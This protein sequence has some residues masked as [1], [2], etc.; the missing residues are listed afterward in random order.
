[1]AP[2]FLPFLATRY[3]YRGEGGDGGIKGANGGIGDV[4][5]IGGD[6]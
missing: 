3:L 2:M 1:M 6:I 4:R 5:G